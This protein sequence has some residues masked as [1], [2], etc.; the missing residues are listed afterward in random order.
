MVNLLVV[1][2]TTKN[3]LKGL[4]ILFVLGALLAL[5]NTAFNQFMI[6]FN[7]LISFL[8]SAIS[9]F[10][11]IL[12]V[13]TMLLFL[14]YLIGAKVVNK[15]IAK[16]PFMKNSA[17]KL[18]KGMPALVKINN[19]LMPAIYLQSQLFKAGT[20]EDHVRCLVA[21]PSIPMP[22][23]AF[24]CYVYPKNLFIIT[25]IPTAEWFSNYLTFFTAHSEEIEYIPYS[26][27]KHQEQ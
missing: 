6:P 11:R 24:P 5:T 20:E 9:P 4:F 16:V 23:T 21:F 7:W 2:K 3:T 17:K 14:G 15:I 12:I 1:K 18:R 10:W 27:W 8:P 19:N 26:S 22:W 13:A 25:N